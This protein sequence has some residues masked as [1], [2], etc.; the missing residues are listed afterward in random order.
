M[1]KLCSNKQLCGSESKKK[2]EN[3]GYHLN[4]QQQKVIELAA[5]T[6]QLKVQSVNMLTDFMNLVEKERE[7]I[8]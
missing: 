3:M 5:Q 6:L 7:E 4:L 8:R 1:S 2:V